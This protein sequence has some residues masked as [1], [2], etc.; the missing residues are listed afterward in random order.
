[1]VQ[2]TGMTMRNSK[3]AGKPPQTRSE[4]KLTYSSF[5]DSD[6]INSQKKTRLNQKRNIELLETK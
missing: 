1:M 3:R 4:K 2:N 6:L 5:M